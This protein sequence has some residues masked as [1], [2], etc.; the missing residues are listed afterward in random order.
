MKA[1]VTFTLAASLLALPIAAHAGQAYPAEQ[2]VK[3]G[4]IEIH[5]NAM[6]TDELQPEVA[7]NYHIERSHNRGLLTIAVLRKNKLGV[8]EPVPAVLAATVVNLS[9]QLAEISMREI[10]EGSAVYYLGEFRVTP[11]DTLKFSVSAQPAGET[12][13]YQANFSRPFF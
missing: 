6:P 12:R 13:K 11:P 9:S 8:A 10:R 4:S 1:L 5:Y 2:V 7:K 3:Y